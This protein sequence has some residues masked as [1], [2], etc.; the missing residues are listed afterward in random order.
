MRLE[1]ALNMVMRAYK[2]GPKKKADVSEKVQKSGRHVQQ[3]L[4]ALSISLPYYHA[5]IGCICRSIFL[6]FQFKRDS[7]ENS[8]RSLCKI[9]F[10]HQELAISRATCVRLTWCFFH[11]S[12]ALSVLFKI[13]VYGFAALFDTNPSKWHVFGLKRPKNKTPKRTENAPQRNENDAEMIPPW[14][15][16]DPR[17]TKQWCKITRKWPILNDFWPNC[18]TFLTSFFNSKKVPKTVNSYKNLF[19]NHLYLLKIA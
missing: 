1:M 14:H 19:K 5:H 3:C 8:F 6:N 10:W 4:K 15:Q 7:S 17:C 16:N 18:W 13:W 12:I 11:G 9:A 2:S